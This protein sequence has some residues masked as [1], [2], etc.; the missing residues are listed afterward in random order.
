MTKNIEI[1]MLNKKDIVISKFKF[2]YYIID[3]KEIILVIYRLEC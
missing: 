1:Y 3:N 2:L